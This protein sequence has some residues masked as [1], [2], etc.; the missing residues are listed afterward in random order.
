MDLPTIMVKDKQ[1][2][3]EMI[4]NESDFDPEKHENIGVK[5]LKVK[6]KNNRFYIVDADNKPVDD[7]VY[8]T[9]ADAKLA[10]QMLQ[11]E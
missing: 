11:G 2:G 10:L 5:K 6:R 7:V 9:E 1:S 8:D 4:I 3:V